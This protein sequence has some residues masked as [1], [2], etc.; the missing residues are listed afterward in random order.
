MEPTHSFLS[1]LASMDYEYATYS[2]SLEG[3]CKIKVQV[4]D[5]NI[6]GFTCK[7]PL[8]YEGGILG[9]DAQQLVGWAL[10]EYRL[11]PGFVDVEYYSNSLQKYIKILD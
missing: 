4:A 11:N 9:F 10:I 1:D 2:E 7:L 6:D 8:T 3:L 5:M